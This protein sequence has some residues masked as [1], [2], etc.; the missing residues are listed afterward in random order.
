MI[1]LGRAARSILLFPV[2]SLVYVLFAG[3]RS[4]MPALDAI[5]QSFLETVYISLLPLTTLRGQFLSLQEFATLN[6]VDYVL[7]T[8]TILIIWSGSSVLLLFVWKMI[9]GRL[10][11]LSNRQ[12][13][14]LGGSMVGVAIGWFLFPFLPS[15][16]SAQI[17]VD[18]TQ[19]LGLMPTH[20]RGFSQGG[21]GQ[22]PEAGY[23]ETGMERLGNLEPSLIRIDHIFDY[24]NVYALEED[25]TPIYNWTELDRVID[26]I[27]SAGAEPL[28]SVSYTPSALAQGTAYGPPTDL[29]AWEEL[30]YQTVHYLN[31]ERGLN[32]HYWEVWNE[33]NLPQF[34]DGTVEAYLALYQATVIGALRAD[35]SVLVGGPGLSSSRRFGG[36][37]A[38]VYEY[39]WIRALVD[40]TVENELPLDFV[41]WHLYSPNPEDYTR[42]IQEHQQWLD[43]LDPQPYLFLTEWNLTSGSSA[44]LDNGESVAYVAATIAELSDSALDQAFFFEP[45]DGKDSWQGGWGM[46]RADG[47]V[48]PVFNGFQLLSALSGERI[49][50]NSTHPDVGGLATRDGDDVSIVLWNYDSGHSIMPVNVALA[51]L[52]GL[53]EFKAAIYGVDETHGNTY[54]NVDGDSLLIETINLVQGEGDEEFVFEVMVPEDGIRLV[55]FEIPSF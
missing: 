36:I 42:S 32:I 23:F 16:N 37:E 29:I 6:A 17:T 5:I 13:W 12:K 41:S 55:Q 50:V 34:W 3:L 21:E 7:M 33:P 31:I 54:Y 14:L 45:I 39:E 28:I 51:G 48:K 46:I 30:V 20:H 4:G 38:L 1:R 35:S 8:A 25:G 22:M 19:S 40:F 53:V 47:V 27:Y 11:F 9:R 52:P 18:F 44:K 15:P 26:A 10:G 43:D 49:L 24:Y 2:I